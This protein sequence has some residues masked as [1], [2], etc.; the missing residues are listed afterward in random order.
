MIQAGISHRNSIRTRNPLKNVQIIENR[1]LSTS[2]VVTLDIPNNIGFQY[3]FP[4][5]HLLNKFVTKK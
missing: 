3:R 5:L 4:A 1:F 2:V